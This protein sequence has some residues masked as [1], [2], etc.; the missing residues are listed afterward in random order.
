MIKNKQELRIYLEQDSKNYKSQVQGWA[1]RFKANLLSNPISEQ[2]YIWRYIKTLRYVEYYDSKKKNNL[3]YYPYYVFLLSKLRKLSHITG[4]QIPP[5]VCGKGLTIWHWG[6]IIINGNTKIGDNCTLYPGVLIGWKGPKEPDCAN[7]GNN[8]FIGSGTKIIG[9]VNI[10][11]N[12]II[13]QNMVI[14]K[15]IPNDSVVVSNS[16]H[17]F[18][19]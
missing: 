8:V 11:S 18:L 19:K 3:I 2:K 4:F 16:V 12:V 7:I 13:G 5:H 15:D 6:S 14:T 1:K 9:G 17:K 10:G